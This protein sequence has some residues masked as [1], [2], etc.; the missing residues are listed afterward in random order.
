MSYENIALISCCAG[1][2]FSMIGISYKFGQNVGILPIQTFMFAAF[3]GTIF[4]GVQAIDSFAQAPPIVYIL[5][6]LVGVTQYCVTRL[7]K[8]I[9]KFGPLSPVWSANMLSF[10]LIIVYSSVVLKEPFTTW[11]LLSTIAAVIAVISA[12][13]N[14]TRQCEFSNHTEKKNKLLSKA[15][16]IYGGLLLLLIFFD[17]ILGSSLK[18]LETFKALN[19]EPLMIQCQT[20]F[21]TVMYFCLGT[22][23]LIDMCI[24]KQWNF[25]SKRWLPL[26]MLATFGTLA[27]MGIISSLVNYPAAIIFTC[28]ASASVLMAA[29]FGAVVFKEHLTWWWYSTVI[30][31]ICAFILANG[32][33]FLSLLQ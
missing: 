24:T 3:T 25:K 16:I 14:A 31:T 20:V 7:V 27:G 9:L 33:F 22:P 29:I 1:I 12:A 32:S 8:I 4:Y 21:L 13:N 17:S 15:T 6:V 2:C 18:Q 28:N 5:A 23:L 26:A 11:N 19:G 10:V 30:A